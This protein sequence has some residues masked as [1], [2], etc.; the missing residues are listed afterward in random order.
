MSELRCSEE[1]VMKS[2]ASYICNDQM[3]ELRYRYFTP[4][5][6]GFPPCTLSHYPD[7]RETGYSNVLR[8]GRAATFVQNCDRIEV[9]GGAVQSCVLWCR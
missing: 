1:I 2:L 8:T 7:N 6:R 5:Y 4:A 9:S 3:S